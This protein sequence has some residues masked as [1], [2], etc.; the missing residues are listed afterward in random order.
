MCGS[1]CSTGAIP[2]L[3]PLQLRTLLGDKLLEVSVGEILGRERG[4]S[5]NP[6]RNMFL[7]ATLLLSAGAICDDG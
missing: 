3:T 2:R 4:K 5:G 1:T 6:L 7:A